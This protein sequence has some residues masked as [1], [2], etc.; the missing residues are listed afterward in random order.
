M[1]ADLFSTTEVRAPQ[2]PKRESTVAFTG[3]FVA[4]S[5][6][7]HFTHP[8]GLCG[9]AVAPF[10]YDARLRAAIGAG[11]AK[12]AGRWLCSGCRDLQGDLS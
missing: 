8:C 3:R 1:N 12:L 2:V 11:D 4:D 6:S 10:G 5:G 7:V 9:H